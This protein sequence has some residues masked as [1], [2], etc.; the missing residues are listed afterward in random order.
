[1][2]WKEGWD[3]VGNIRRKQEKNVNN[4]RPRRGELKTPPPR[5]A[6]REGHLGSR[7]PASGLAQLQQHKQEA[8]TLLRG[9]WGSE[10]GGGEWLSQPNQ[11]NRLEGA[12]KLKNENTK[13]EAEG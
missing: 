11:Q 1:M 9:G 2:L 5:K 3:R 10:K 7:G 4:G 13:S 6:G 8:E 12:R